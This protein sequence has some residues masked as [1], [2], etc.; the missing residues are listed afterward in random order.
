MVIAYVAVF[1]VVPEGLFSVWA[2]VAPL[3]ADPPVMPPPTVGAGQAKVDPATLETRLILV[4]TPLQTMKDVGGVSVGIS[5]IRKAGEAPD[6]ENRP[7]TL[8]A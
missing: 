8:I 6:V 7:T 2:I 5:P 1:V 3:P 4:N